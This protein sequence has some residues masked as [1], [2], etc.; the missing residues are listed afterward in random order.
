MPIDFDPM[1]DFMTIVDAAESVT[2][3]RRGSSDE[4][5]VATAWRSAD[6]QSEAESAGGYAVQADVVW[7]FEWPAGTTL[8]LLGDQ[9]KDASS[10]CYTVLAVNQLQGN[11]RL[12]C[13]TRSLR[14]AHGLDCLVD[15]EQAVWDEGAITGW[16]T[17]RP[18][19]HARIQPQETTVDETSDPITSTATCRI[20]LD[21]ETPL[22]HNHRI[23]AAG[24][25]V[26][27]LLSYAQAERI[28]ALPVAVVRGE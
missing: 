26:Y 15:I 22:D 10:E 9:I 27:R 25:A 7:Q 17:F 8:P 24:G 4:V 6:R 13:E 14:I 3:L 19:V 11:T 16:S 20:L 12:R 21:D 1:G 23:V 18:A 2:L 28:D 5:S